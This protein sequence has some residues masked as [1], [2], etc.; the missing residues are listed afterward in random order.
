M[1]VMLIGGLGKGVTE[2][3]LMM[4]VGGNLNYSM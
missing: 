4:L 1:G 3:G 2:G